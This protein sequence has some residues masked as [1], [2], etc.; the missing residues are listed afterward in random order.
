MGATRD[1]AAS[2]D[3]WLEGYR[4]GY[5]DRDEE[6]REQLLGGH[7]S[8]LRHSRDLMKD[9]EHNMVVRLD[10]EELAMVHALASDGDEPIA[11]VVR[12]WIRHEY[13]ERFGAK[14]PPAPKLK[15]GAR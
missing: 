5:H 12:R 14:K 13:V 7:T 15:H 4:R 2:D 10:G 1:I 6:L 3:A 8:I 11:R 9:R